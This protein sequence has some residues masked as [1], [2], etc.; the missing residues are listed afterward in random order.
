ML[1]SGSKNSMSGS[2]TGSSYAATCDFMRN[3][4]HIQLVLNRVYNVIQPACCNEE[5]YMLV[6]GQANKLMP[7]RQTKELAFSTKP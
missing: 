7:T 2:W 1:S 4:T 3:L 6:I 5:H